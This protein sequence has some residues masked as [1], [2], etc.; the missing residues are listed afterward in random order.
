MAP[1][2]LGTQPGYGALGWH[3]RR[4]VAQ[5]ISLYVR[6]ASFRLLRCNRRSGARRMGTAASVELFKLVRRLARRKPLRHVRTELG[7]PTAACDR[8]PRRCA[9]RRLG[10]VAPVSSAFHA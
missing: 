8:R 7:L 2:A 4:T 10:C 1:A 3:R 5:L 6:I 9:V